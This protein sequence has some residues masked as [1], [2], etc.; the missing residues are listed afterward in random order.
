MPTSRSDLA[1]LVAF[2]VLLA[3]FVTVAAVSTL[4][5]APWSP[6]GEHRQQLEQPA[7]GGVTRDA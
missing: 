1:A 3:A 5:P 6:V 4:S 7:P 2:V